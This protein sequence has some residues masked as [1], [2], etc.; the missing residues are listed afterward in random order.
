MGATHELRS[1]EILTG[2]RDAMSK[3]IDVHEHTARIVNEM[4]RL[5]DACEIEEAEEG[6][7]W[8]EYTMQL[9]DKFVVFVAC[10]K[11]PLGG[12]AADYC[13]SNAME[14]V[15]GYRLRLRD[16]EEANGILHEMRV[17]FHKHALDP[18]RMFG[19]VKY[20]GIP[21]GRH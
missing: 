15:L 7:A 3:D 17:Q 8:D 9:V 5:L 1:K 2:V 11:I 19:E 20:A 6:D 16:D 14:G 10:S 21:I 4:W 18:R 13:A 12:S